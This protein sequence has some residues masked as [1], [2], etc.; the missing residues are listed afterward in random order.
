M[1]KWN[2]YLFA[3]F[4]YSL[5]AGLIIG[6]TYGLITLITMLAFTQSV[7][8]AALLFFITL[9]AA[10]AFVASFWSCACFMLL[11]V[12]RGGG[13][14]ELEAWLI[15]GGAALMI[16]AFFVLQTQDPDFW[17]VHTSNAIVSVISVILCRK[18]YQSI[19]N[20]RNSLTSKT[21]ETLLNPEV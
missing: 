14:P 16:N 9:P 3:G 8:G 12:L 7:D 19:W 4:V 1:M 2:Q 6:S 10:V 18:V 13:R 5:I 15:P 17:V 21:S 20:K 11:R